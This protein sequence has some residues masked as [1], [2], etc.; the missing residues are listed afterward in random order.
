MSFYLFLCPPIIS[1]EESS[2]S[3]KCNDYRLQIKQILLNKSHIKY[4]FIAG[5][6]NDISEIIFTKQITETIKFLSSLNKKIIIMGSVPNLKM[7]GGKISTLECIE[8][9]LTPIHKFLPIKNHNCSSYPLSKFEKQL[10]YAAI[11]KNAVKKYQNVSY[12][13]PFQYLC[14]SQNCYFVKDQKLLYA[15]EDHLNITGSKYIINSLKIN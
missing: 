7:A 4:V 10:E 11:I 9:K 8:N 1:D 5:R 3:N 13:D 2:V 15:D 14:D 12:F 6:W